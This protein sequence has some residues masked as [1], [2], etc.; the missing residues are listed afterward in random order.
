MSFFQP[1]VMA[2]KSMMRNKGR[3]VLTMLG[4]IIGVAA[5]IILV[6]LMQHTTEQV[7][8]QMLMMGTNRIDIN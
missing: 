3:S 1:F 7:T 5:V 2:V 6:S 4:I 8:E